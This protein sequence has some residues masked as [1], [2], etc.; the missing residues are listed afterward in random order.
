MRAWVLAVALAAA[1]TTQLDAQTAI[2]RRSSNEKAGYLGF[3]FTETT[4]MGSNQARVDKIIVGD[5]LKDSPAEKAGLK[6]GDEIMRVN[7]LVATNGKFSALS[8]TLE[9][10]DTI[11][12][13]VKREGKER[14]LTVVAGKRPNEMSYYA[15]VT[16]DSVRRLTWRYLDSARVQLDSLH[17]PDITILRSDSML[18]LRVMPGGRWVQDSL[19][20]KRDSAAW[21][22]FREREGD[23]L[24]ML[25]P[26]MEWER[27]EGGPGMIFRTT[28]LGARSIGGAELTE[29]DPAMQDY[30]KTDHGV[31]TLRVA[32][33]TPAARAGLQ[34]GDVIVK[35]DD[36]AVRTVAELRRA[37]SAKPE[38]VK[39]EVIRKGSTKTLEL[40]TRAR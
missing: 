25:P 31:L 39:L 15:V 14:D 32:S 28:E 30:F 12:L 33:E 19:F 35:I 7:G 11:V 26:Q 9:E 38:G 37:I 6:A 16:P 29:L 4:S 3:R 27:I 8:R 18:D 17:L 2:Y 21:R 24:R 13:H 10:G 23:R 36:R 34:P 20:F 5:V 1:A 40:K 22:V